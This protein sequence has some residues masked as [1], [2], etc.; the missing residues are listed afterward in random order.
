MNPNS[1]GADGDRG[2]RKYGVPE[3]ILWAFQKYEIR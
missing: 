3:T 1:I 2:H